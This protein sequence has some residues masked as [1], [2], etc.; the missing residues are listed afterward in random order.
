MI[1]KIKSYYCDYCGTEIDFGNIC[2]SCKGKKRK[3]VKLEKKY[4]KGVRIDIANEDTCL[5]NSSEKITM[6]TF[7]R[8]FD[9]V[10]KRCTPLDNFDYFMVLPKIYNKH[11]KEVKKVVNSYKKAGMKVLVVFDQRVPRGKR[12]T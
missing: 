7:K 1:R 8:C 12:T 5:I 6:E 9:E 3:G 10:K 4:K 2:G 11:P